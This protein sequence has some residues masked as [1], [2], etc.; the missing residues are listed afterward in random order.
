MKIWYESTNAQIWKEH[1]YTHITH[2]HRERDT[3]KQTGVTA[4]E[5]FY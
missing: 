1:D 2:T 5:H 4:K 3:H